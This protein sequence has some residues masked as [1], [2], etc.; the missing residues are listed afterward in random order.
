MNFATVAYDLERV[1]LS[2]GQAARKGQNAGAKDFQFEH[3]DLHLEK[4]NEGIGFF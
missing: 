4:V 1:G 3:E 2:R